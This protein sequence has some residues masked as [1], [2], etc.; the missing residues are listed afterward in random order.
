MKFTQ[1]TL[2]F[3]I[4][5]SA[6]DNPENDS[7]PPADERKSIYTHAA[8]MGLKGK[9]KKATLMY[10]EYVTDSKGDPLPIDSNTLNIIYTYTFHP[11]GNLDTI[12]QGDIVDKYLYSSDTNTGVVRYFPGPPQHRTFFKRTWNTSKKYT[13][14]AYDLLYNPDTTDPPFITQTFWL[15]HDYTILKVEMSATSNST[16][17]YS[18]RG[19]T[20]ITNI[21]ETTDGRGRNYIDKAIKIVLKRDKYGNPTHTICTYNKT[22][23]SS[24]KTLELNTY[25]Y[26][27]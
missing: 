11:D 21:V 10:A 17:T 24:D 3:L 6:C 27:E 4:L 5:L 13:L 8:E 16:T 18:K 20:T 2:V 15:D 1:F 14:E 26:Y 23:G 19:D 12:A 7:S 22:N 25:E 9:P